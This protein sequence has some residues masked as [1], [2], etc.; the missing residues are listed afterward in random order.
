[1]ACSSPPAAEPSTPRLCWAA[2]SCAKPSAGG[3]DP[4]QLLGAVD[5]VYQE[6]RQS[7]VEQ[8]EARRAACAATGLTHRRIDLWE[9]SGR[10]HSTYPHLDDA[11]RELAGRFP[12]LG[13]GAGYSTEAGVD[14]AD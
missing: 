14:D 9:R 2:P 13:I 4:E 8:R 5:L 10:D 1:M 6:E 7:T 11:A 3:V 12:A